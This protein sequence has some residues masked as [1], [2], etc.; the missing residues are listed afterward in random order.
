METEIDLVIYNNQLYYS[1]YRWRKII[2]FKMI[3]MALKDID[4]C[5]HQLTKYEQSERETETERQTERERDRERYQY[6]NANDNAV[7]M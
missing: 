4:H 1:Q 3:I 7:V 6:R 2:I 5:Q